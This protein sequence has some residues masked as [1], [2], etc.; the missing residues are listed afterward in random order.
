MFTVK[1]DKH[2]LERLKLLMSDEDEN[3]CIRLKEYI[4]CTC[5]NAKTLLAP[6]VDE[7]DEVEDEAVEV[8]GIKFIA[9]ETFINTYGPDFKLIFEDGKLQAKPNHSQNL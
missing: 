4:G 2:I 7:M 8:N 1:A 3:A 6:S 9:S 5:C